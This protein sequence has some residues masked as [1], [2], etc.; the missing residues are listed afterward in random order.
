MFKKV[1]KYNNIYE[2]Y[3]LY[4]LLLVF[5][6]YSLYFFRWFV[7]DLY[8]YFRYANNFVKG[9]GIVYN[10]GEYV[11][12]FSSF[13]WFLILSVFGFM[14]LSLETSSKVASLIFSVLSLLVVFKIS[15]E[16]GLEK[17]SL[18][19]VILTAF[20]LPFILWSISGFEIS[21]YSLLLLLCFYEI[22]II[23]KGRFNIPS[24]ILLLTLISLTRPEGFLF[25]FAF[26]V[27]IF[28]FAKDSR[29]YFF[30][31][32]SVYLILF[33]GF[34]S[35]RYFYFGELLPNT[36]YAKLDYG[37]IGYN[38][39]R[40]YRYGVLYVLKF[41]LRNLQFAVLLLY[42]IFRIKFRLKEKNIILLL[43]FI[44]VQFVFVVYAGGDWMEHFRFVVCV[45]PFL[46]LLS[47]IAL[48]DLYKRK[49]SGNIDY[50]IL[51]VIG[52]LFLSV[53]IY[54]SN[55]D[56]VNT[57]KILWNRVKC[58]STD[59]KNIIP[60]NS[61]VANGSAGVIPYYLEDVNFIDVI[62][63]NDKYIAKYGKR[64]D[65]WFEKYST[66]YVFERNP[67]WIILWKRKNGSGEFTTKN[68]SPALK[69]IESDRRFFNFKSFKVYDVL[70]D[71]RI[72]LFKK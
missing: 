57:E 4:I 69:Y 30:Y 18:F 54:F 51:Y 41:F 19:S 47:T 35:F 7:D 43:T 67:E 15:K 48:K 64:D 46:S 39:V 9:K 10:A 50:K 70:E 61:L 71:T 40:I 28:F 5:I 42:L 56:I 37:I 24:L 65:I 63:L 22:I 55:I 26:L 14:K 53:N 66:D 38:E 49:L 32:L 6:G 25:S 29:K 11:E 72:E 44:F 2:N 1:G 34:L 13:I 20:N 31:T 3:F 8:I 21:F 62:G 23:K 36:Y 58:V 59:L 45:I 52:I 17:W 60:S 16:L 33:I 68:T 12:G 27:A